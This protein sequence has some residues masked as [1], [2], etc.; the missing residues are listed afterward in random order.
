MRM[1]L[2][3]AGMIGSTLAQLA[4]DLGHEV[5]LIEQ[6]KDRAEIASKD[7]DCRVLH[8]DAA[9]G[10]IFDEAGIARAEA[11]VATTGD[12]AI[13]MMS[14]MLAREAEVQHRIS[15][16]NDRRHLQMFESLGARVLVDPEVLIAKHLIG[17]LLQPELE[18]VV[19]MEDGTQVATVSLAS[20]SPLIGKS[21]IQIGKE[22]LLP[23][24]T[25]IVCI[26]REGKVMVPKG[27]SEL[28]EGDV[29][30][31]FSREALSDK[32]LEAFGA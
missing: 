11:L 27:T 19:P 31:L 10:G 13:N 6:R 18:D 15:I 1:I 3:G 23:S 25:L 32:D 24:D 2:V 5:T 28:E 26:R 16:V 14:V 8:A 20:A 12:D 9:V 30:T 22:S 7:L 29:L 4:S 17:L 21:L